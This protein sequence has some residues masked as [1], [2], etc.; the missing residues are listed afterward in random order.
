MGA[1]V[2]LAGRLVDLAANLPRLSGTVSDADR[3]QIAKVANRIA[4]IRDDLT[5]GLVRR[6][7]QNSEAAEASP[8]PCS[9]WRDRRQCP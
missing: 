6:T 4:A 9:L 8:K 1:L 2:A 3:E 5:K 7:R